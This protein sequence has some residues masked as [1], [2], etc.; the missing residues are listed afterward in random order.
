M[1]RILLATMSLGIG[2]AETHIVELSEKLAEA[3][4]KV[5]IISNGGVY[6]ESIR[7]NGITH[8]KA[9]LHTKNPFSLVKSY[10]RIRKAIILNSIDIVHAHARIPAFICNII[11]KKLNI[12]FVTTVHY[13]FRTSLMFR[14]FTRWGSHTLSVSQ[15]VQDY[16][17]QN[18]HYDSGRAGITVNGINTR[19]FHPM[20]KDADAMEEFSIG[21]DD[22]VIGTVCRI[23]RG[24]S[25][26]AFM[27]ADIANELDEEIKNLRIIVI[28]GGNQFDKL[29]EKVRAV[30]KKA[31]RRLVEL[32]GP[33]SDI[34]RLLSVMDIFTGISRAALE[35]MAMAKPVVLCGDMGYLGIMDEESREKAMETNMTC[36][37]MA[38]PSNI[39]L[40]TDLLFLYENKEMRRINAGLNL[41]TVN[42]N[43][44]VDRMCRDALYMYDKA[45]GVME[46]SPR[47]H[48][49]ILS[50]YYGFENSGDEAMLS[51]IIDE[52][53]SKKRNIRLLVLTKKPAETKQKYGVDAIS[54]S[55]PFTLIKAFKYSGTLISG[56]G[57]LIQD[58]TSFQSMLYYT[59]LMKYAF[60]RR[61]KVMLYANGIGP[62]QR[63]LS[64]RIAG[65]IL[66]K[67]D[68][69]T[70]R[71]PN[72]YKMLREIG[73]NKPYIS[74]TA[75]PVMGL[76]LPSYEINEKVLSEYKIPADGRRAVF[77]VRPWKGLEGRY[78]PIFA[79]IADYLFEEY[80]LTP[81][82]IPLHSK[83]D[84]KVCQDIIGMMKNNAYL[85]ES[86]RSAMDLISIISTAELVIGMRLHSLI[87]ASVARIPVI[88]IVYDPKVR[89]FIELMDQEDGGLIE[90]I[91]A[92]DIKN[93]VLKIMNER[94]EYIGRISSRMEG[95]K[96]QCRRN[97]EI[98]VGLIE[99]E[100]FDE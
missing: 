15:D 45:F 21:P 37:G 18:Y 14:K 100:P 29:S 91:T 48:H 19:T 30:N 27:L 47:Y 85:V 62:L 40:R 97:A 20:D 99:G 22:F 9:P 98:A 64:I 87:Y 75:D 5:F 36:R 59:G 8:I 50:G 92:D 31:G 55:N 24:S 11:C 52:L 35:S 61:M 49:A 73:V 76:E 78:N 25:K 68:V 57:N 95:L 2:G 44:T 13:K 17:I 82:F 41:E 93:R 4:H 16:L 74:I 63:K 77:S 65:R 51:S 90:N 69:I 72:S 34:S 12:P 67:T 71:E 54:R 88:G 10:F 39:K 96:E 86:E 23:D 80:K 89:Y 32:A 84:T 38:S 58:L 42:E 7:K 66:N 53:R 6:E 56:G 60:M 83:K 94:D 1:N 46:G 33:R 79:E 26:T 70:V 3:G 28:G 43:Y 81:V